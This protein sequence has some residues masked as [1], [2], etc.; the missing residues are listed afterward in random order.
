VS[1]AQDRP[2][3]SILVPVFDGGQYLRESLDSLLAQTYPSCEVLVLDDASR[4][5]TPD[6]I[7]SYGSAVRS[8]R[9]EQ[10]QGI[11]ENVNA[12]IKIARGELI[13]VYH[14]DDVYHP[15]IVEQEVAFLERYPEAGAAFCLDAWI[16]AE[17]RE[18]GRLEIP[19][20]LRRH[21]PIPFVDIFNALLRYKNIFLVCPTAM[22]RA[23][24]Y[25]ELGGYRQSLFR[26]SSD[27]DM[28]IRIAC[29]HPIGIVQDYLMSYRHFHGSSSHRYH[30]LRTE[31]NRLSEI[32]D[33]HLE[34][35]AREVAE[36]D[37]LTSYE[38]HRSED[39]IMIAIAHYINGDLRQAREVLRS[40]RLGCLLRSPQ[41]QGV[42][43]TV[44]AAVLWVLAR[45]PRIPVIARAFHRRW[46]EKEAGA[47]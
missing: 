24:V 2:L 8:H 27:L 1:E 28:W 30:H 10:N 32:M 15:T 26:N 45:V 41:V 31:P 33:Y 6:I 12:G 40:V 38:A 3:V 9:Q 47:T 29:R 36:P 5:E 22:V 23:S 19:E 34:D 39:H 17:G 44:L 4:D 43:L 37:A 42:R 46:H 21:D 11:Y 14:A 18:Y 7:V 16:D 25:K 13:A 35:G 20:E